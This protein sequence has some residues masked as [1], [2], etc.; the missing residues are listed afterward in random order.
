MEKPPF[1]LMDTLTINFDDGD[2]VTF[3]N[4]VA[5]TSRAWLAAYTTTVLV[6]GAI[7]GALVKQC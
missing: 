5:F 4:L 2:S 6:V 7:V 3:E 1:I